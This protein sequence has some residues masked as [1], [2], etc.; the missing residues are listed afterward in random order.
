VVLTGLHAPGV[1]AVVT[2]FQT[3]DRDVAVLHHDLRDISAGPGATG[4][5]RPD[6]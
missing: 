1:E 4:H 3:L 6:A 2:R 5:R